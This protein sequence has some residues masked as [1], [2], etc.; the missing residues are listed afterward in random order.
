MWIS[1]FSRREIHGMGR[2]LLRAFHNI[3]T[4]DAIQ[5][6][7]AIKSAAPFFLTNDIHLPSSSKLQILVVNNLSR[8]V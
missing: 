1:I 7:T 5:M 6:A 4:P 3:R 2:G 8:S